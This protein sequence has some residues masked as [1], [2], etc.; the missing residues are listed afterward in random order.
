[1]IDN[2]TYE[3]M[4]ARVQQHRDRMASVDNIASARYDSRDT[5]VIVDEINEYWADMAKYYDREYDG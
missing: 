3:K 1:M 5:N 2:S 4:L